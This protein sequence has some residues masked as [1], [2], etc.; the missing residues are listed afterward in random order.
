M[1]LA[2]DCGN[3]HIVAGVFDG[4][5]LLCHWRLSSDSRKTE[6]EYMVLLVGL[7]Q[8][9]GLA[10]GDIDA[11]ILGSVVPDLNFVLKKLARKHFKLIP[12]CIDSRTDTGMPILMHNPAEVGAD[13]IINAVAAHHIYGGDLIVVDFGTATTFDAVSAAG[14]YLGG[15]IA[16]GIEIS[17]RALFTHAARLANIPL[18]KPQHAIGRSTAEGLQSGTLWGFGGQVDGVVAKMSEEMPAKPTVV[19]TG[20]LAAF[21]APYSTRIDHVDPLLTLEGL[22]LIYERQQ[23]R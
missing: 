15:A 17:R 10:L 11:M 21:I 9:Q 8:A 13:R 16:P 1:L 5:E 20:G 3:T 6:D 2:L 4:Q 19:A 18:E 22:R 23:Q 14:E 12:V 7:L